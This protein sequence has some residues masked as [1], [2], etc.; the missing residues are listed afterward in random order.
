MGRRKRKLLSPQAVMAEHTYSASSES[1][2]ACTDRDKTLWSQEIEEME[3]REPHTSRMAARD[4]QPA[5]KKQR[6]APSPPASLPAPDTVGVAAASEDPSVIVNSATCASSSVSDP[7]PASQQGDVIVDGIRP[8]PPVLVDAAPD[9]STPSNPTSAPVNQGHVVDGM[10]VTTPSAGSA[11]PGPLSVQPADGRPHRRRRLDFPAAAECS[12]LEKQYEWYVALHR[13]HGE[14]E[15]LF[16]EGRSRAYITVRDDRPF[17]Q[18][19]V[20]DGFLDVVMLENVM[21]R[22]HN[23]IVYNV[24]VYVNVNLLETPENFLWLKRRTVGNFNRPQLIGA[25]VGPIPKE[26]RLL[27]VGRCRVGPYTPEPD[28]CKNCS[29]WGHQEWRCRSA[30]RCRYCAGT[31]SSSVCLRKIQDQVPV[32]RRCCNCNGDHNAHWHACPQKPK[33]RREPAHAHHPHDGHSRVVFRPA[34][35]PVTS[36]WTQ[37]AP[38]LDHYPPLP[39]SS[40]ATLVSSEPHA[41]VLQQQP[42]HPNTSTA[43][44]PAVGST[45]FI[46]KQILA[47]VDQMAGTLDVVKKTLDTTVSRVATLEQKCAALAPVRDSATAPAS[48][49]PP[50]PAPAS[51]PAQAPASPSAPALPSAPAP[52]HVVQSPVGAMDTDRVPPQTA[53]LTP[54]VDMVEVGPVT[55][56]GTA[57][58][59]QSPS[60]VLSA[61]PTPWEAALLKIMDRMDT[62]AQQV[63]SIQ[64]CITPTELNASLREL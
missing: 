53:P 17:Y 46:L 31:H 40:A 50:A 35:P 52:Y 47:R 4:P 32:Q 39:G 15:P 25:V 43:S 44:S 27:G 20:T 14:L 22:Q 16:K 2:E 36:A 60:P 57:A 49:S 48:A 3:T 54:A 42:A 34:P 21:E 64:H 61:A 26:V 45:D 38:S 33:P 58:H 12:T 6:T 30:P 9:A 59:H 51:H 37:G 41:Q 8:V 19:L 10:P 7:A 56:V 63:V 11:A 62:L 55:A 1:A 28:M 18:S 5:P 29:R 23:V 24:P 13:Q